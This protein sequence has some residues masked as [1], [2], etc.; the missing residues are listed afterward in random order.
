MPYL[1]GFFSYISYFGDPRPT[2]ASTWARCVQNQE[3]QLRANKAAVF[4]GV[5]KLLVT[6]DNCR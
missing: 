3:S 4:M 1:K 5:W 6:S 2:L